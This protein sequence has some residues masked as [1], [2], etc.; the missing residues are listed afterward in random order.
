MVV[1]SNR[2][3]SAGSDKMGVKSGNL[4][5][6]E[7]PKEWLKFAEADLDAAK[8]LYSGKLHSPAI[9]HLQQASEK[10]AKGILIQTKILPNYIESKVVKKLRRMLGFPSSRPRD[11]GH[12]WLRSF[13]N[14]LENF[15][16]THERLA[17]MLESLPLN[18]EVKENIKKFKDKIPGLREKIYAAKSVEV[19]LEPSLEEVRSTV[20]GCRVVLD[21]VKPL[22]ENLTSSISSTIRKLGISPL[23]RRTERYFR[24]RLDRKTKNNL[25]KILKDEEFIR[26]QIKHSIILIP[27][28]SLSMVLTP[29]EW[30]TRY[31]DAEQKIDYG[32]NHPLSQCFLE[33]EEILRKCLEA[34]E[35]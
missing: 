14:D 23:M 11:Y 6:V 33:I 2:T 18:R 15:V 7:G 29:H 16:N 9:F 3:A 10:L 5:V 27:L 13:L 25:E 26:K 20:D 4:E 28:G 34:V 21:L 8:V 30:P 1:S 12:K 32:E 35:F 31:P 22:S 17:K 19:K 24:T